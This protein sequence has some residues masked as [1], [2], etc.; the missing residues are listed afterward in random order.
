MSAEKLIIVTDEEKEGIKRRLQKTDE[1]INED[2]RVLREWFKKQPHLPQNEGE[3]Q[4]FHT[5]P[6]YII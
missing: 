5:L 1:E 6:K 3:Y 4:T 2:I